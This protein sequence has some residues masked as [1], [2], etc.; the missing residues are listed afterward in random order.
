MVNNK[1]YF[2]WL[3][4][5]CVSIGNH[6]LMDFYNINYVATVFSRA[7]WYIQV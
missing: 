1:T 7:S 6:Y 2:T 4:T 3:N 5:V